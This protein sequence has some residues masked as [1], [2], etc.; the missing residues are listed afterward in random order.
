M[1]ALHES[2]SPRLEICSAPEFQI[3]RAS[4]QFTIRHTVRRAEDSFVN[5]HEHS[6]CHV[7]IWYLQE[8]CYREVFN[9]VPVEMTPGS[10]LIVPP[11]SR[12]FCHAPSGPVIKSFCIDCTIDFLE[13]ILPIEKAQR[14]SYPFF[15]GQDGCAV[16]R[17]SGD[18]RE[19]FEHNLTSFFNAYKI[20]E[21]KAF[22]INKGNLTAIFE[23]I[24]NNSA[25]YESK[26][27]VLFSKY[28][29]MLRLV[30]K[31]VEKHLSEKIMLTDICNMLYMSHSQFNRVFKQLTG[32]TFSEYIMCVRLKTA[33]GL[34]TLS[35]YSVDE[36][37]QRCGFPN[38]SHFHRQFLKHFGHTPRKHRLITEPMRKLRHLNH[39]EYCLAVDQLS[40]A[41]I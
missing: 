20:D 38:K 41:E 15:F 5:V 16:Y 13:T 35:D 9:G 27:S 7:H 17:M 14:F 40:S 3:L 37:G 24:L 28:S 30:S 12:H 10:L 2:N 21:N 32:L 25:K 33:A 19:E 39:K 11:F 34:L 8:G 6:H 29:N 4:R 23:Q 22:V 31:H 1:Q 36:I 18:E 26:I